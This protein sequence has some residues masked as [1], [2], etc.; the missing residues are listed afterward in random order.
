MNRY[1]ATFHSHFGALRYC[2]ALE[3][4]GIAAKPMPVPRRVSSSCG[5]CVRYEHSVPVDRNDCE[6]ECVYLERGETFGKGAVM[7]DCVLRK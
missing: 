1:I 3:S 5:T 6:L 7:P 2:K 4:S